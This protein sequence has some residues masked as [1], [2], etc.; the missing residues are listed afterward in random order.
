MER[1]RCE[2]LVGITL[3]IVYLLLNLNLAIQLSSIV[4]K[5]RFIRFFFNLGLYERSVYF[6]SI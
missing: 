5:F 3:E 4:L 2:R 6:N 1:T